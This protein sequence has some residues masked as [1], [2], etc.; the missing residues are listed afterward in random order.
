VLGV[1]VGARG[2]PGLQF[3]LQFTPVQRSSREYMHAI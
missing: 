2:Q 1:N 3:G